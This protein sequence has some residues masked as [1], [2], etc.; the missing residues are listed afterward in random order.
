MTSGRL[1]PEA[2]G[3]KG[4]CRV[5]NWKATVIAHDSDAEFS[6]PLDEA[7]IAEAEKALNIEFPSDLRSFFFEAGGLVADYGCEVIWTISDIINRNNEFRDSVSFRELYMPFNHL[8]FFG[9][10]GGGDQFA[11]AIHADGIVHKH[12]VYRWEHETDARS[13]FASGLSQF[14]EK[15]LTSAD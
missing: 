2:D 8:L 6:P 1:R 4:I 11:L 14:L 13:W 12:D 9:D 7:I 5:M 15:R 10:D 3:E